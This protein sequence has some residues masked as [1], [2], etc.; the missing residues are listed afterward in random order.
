M[1]NFDSLIGK[2][3]NRLLVI[4]RADNIVQK[5]GR[6][7]VAWSCLCD[8]GNRTIVVTNLLKSGR[9]KSCG[10]I[11]T[12]RNRTYFTKHNGSHERLYKVWCSIKKR[13]YNKNFR[14]FMDYGGRG[15]AV[16]DEWLH[17]YSAFRDWAMA[18]GYNPNAKFGECTI[19]RIHVNGNY[20]PSNCRWATI[21][22][23]NRN[24]RGSKNK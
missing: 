14:Q 21:K 6:S 16:C 5:D 20:E 24:K 2:K 11:K 19:D 22:E 4:S 1:A 13:C 15:I 7:R 23:Q 17:N 12:E 3:F 9:V 18:N 10:C 8:C